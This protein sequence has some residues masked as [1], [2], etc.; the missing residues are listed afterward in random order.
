MKRE[1]LF[2][3]EFRPKQG[4]DGEIANLPGG[5]GFFL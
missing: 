1:L 4:C 5:A 2:I 3:K